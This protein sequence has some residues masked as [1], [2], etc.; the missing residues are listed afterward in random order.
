L[1]HH[2]REVDCRGEELEHG[3]RDQLDHALRFLV[4]PFG[5]GLEGID[6][7]APELRLHR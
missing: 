3:E 6:R 7:P 2:D 1:D 5:L 4:E